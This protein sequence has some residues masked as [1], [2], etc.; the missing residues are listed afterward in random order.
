[1]QN[2]NN[3]EGKTYSSIFCDAPKNEYQKKN[4][5]VNVFSNRLEHLLLSS[6]MYSMMLRKRKPQKTDM[7]D[8]RFDNPVSIF[9]NKLSNTVEENIAVLSGKKQERY[10]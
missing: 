10:K 3:I 7:V 2:I 6:A 8:W 1:M 4:D 5:P 9:K